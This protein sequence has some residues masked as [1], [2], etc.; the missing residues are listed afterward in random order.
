[1]MNLIVGSCL[2]VLLMA[3]SAVAGSGSADET[4]PV[5]SPVPLAYSADPL[6][7]LPVNTSYA[8]PTVALIS[9]N[10]TDVL[11]TITDMRAKL[12]DFGNLALD[13]GISQAASGFED[14][15]NMAVAYNL[16]A[17]QDAIHAM[18]GDLVSQNSDLIQDF[19]LTPQIPAGGSIFSEASF[20]GSVSTG[21]VG[22][23]F[24]Q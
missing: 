4:S 17:E 3:T 21:S 9:A 1:M 23:F 7:A 19:L 24:A 16:A 14:H 6:A 22:G 12:A 15:W 20:T 5:E 13:N 8:Q 10:R 11:Q 2:T 18:I